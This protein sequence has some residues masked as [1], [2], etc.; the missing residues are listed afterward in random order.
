[1]KQEVFITGFNNWGKTTII[2]GLFNQKR[3]HQGTTYQISGVNADFTVESHSNDDWGGARWVKHVLKRINAETKSDLNLLTALCPTI[4]KNNEFVNLLS[5]VPFTSYDNLYI[6][7][8]EYKWDNHAKL[9]IENIIGE[10]NKIP[11]VNFILIKEDQ[12]QSTANERLNEKI[13]QIKQK[14]MNIFS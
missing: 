6:F 5:N 10:G 2:E 11:N 7:L 4:E 3:F 13:N 1:M 9:I 12:D 14:L 8:I